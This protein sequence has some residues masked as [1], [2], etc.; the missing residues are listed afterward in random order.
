MIGCIAG[1]MLP[2][3]FE[4]FAGFFLLFT[5]LATVFAA[6]RHAAPVEEVAAKTALVAEPAAAR[7]QCATIPRHAATMASKVPA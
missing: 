1:C 2:L 6:R 4:M 5:L 7:A 3:A